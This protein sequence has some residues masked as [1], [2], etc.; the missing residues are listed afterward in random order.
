[1]KL[2]I[3]YENDVI[4]VV[5]FGDTEVPDTN[6][7]WQTH[8]GL[9]EIIVEGAKDSKFDAKCIADRRHYQ[10]DEDFERVRNDV[11][12]L[13]RQDLVSPVP[14]A[15]EISAVNAETEQKETM[16]L[17]ILWR[18]DNEAAEDLDEAWR[19]VE[20]VADGDAMKYSANNRY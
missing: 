15:I 13:T 11:K 9:S 18:T 8:C 4:R 10:M 20:A 17:K 5:E 19:I 6:N 7:D 3:I 14:N 1:M 16:T 12:M 2:K